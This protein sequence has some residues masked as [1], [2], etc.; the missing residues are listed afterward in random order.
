MSLLPNSELV[1]RAWLRVV[2]GFSAS[3]V[4]ATLPGDPAT[5]ATNGFIQV[6]VVGGATSMDLPMARPVLSVDCWTNNPSSGKPPWGKANQLA[7]IIRSSCYGGIDDPNPTQRVV[8]M[9]VSGY[10]R[11]AVFSAYWVS[12]PRR[13]P[14]DDARFARMGGDL[15]L[16]WVARP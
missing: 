14:A 6:V 1:A 4:G 7:E 15:Q 9:P 13:R 8:D 3:A 2:A 10:Q 11:A 5:W 12:E 16:H